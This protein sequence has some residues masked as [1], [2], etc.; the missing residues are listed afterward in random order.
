MSL[1][2]DWELLGYVK[3]LFPFS[4]DRIQSISREDSKLFIATDDDRRFILKLVEIGP[5]MEKFN[6]NIGE[7]Q[8]LFYINPETKEPVF[9]NKTAY[10]SE[11]EAI[12]A[13]MVINVQDKTTHKRQAYK[14]SV[15]HKWHV[16]R[17]K[18]ILTDE[19]KRKLK[20]KH[21]IR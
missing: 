16:G 19:D 4:T 12:H 10:E 8:T 2:I 1:P 20:I 6:N 15:C 13:A 9:R 17:G 21:N 11:K 14:C 5:V 7:H 18:T 3:G